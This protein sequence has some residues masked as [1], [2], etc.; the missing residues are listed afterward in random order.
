MINSKRR[1]VL[2]VGDVDNDETSNSLRAGGSRQRRKKKK[3]DITSLCYQEFDDRNAKINEFWMY[4]LEDVSIF[5][6]QFLETEVCYGKC[7]G[8]DDDKQTTGADK[9]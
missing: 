7:E 9:C 6:K 1:S 3:K 5:F 2:I 8:A 4:S